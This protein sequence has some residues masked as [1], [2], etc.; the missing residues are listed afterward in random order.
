MIT[1]VGKFKAAIWSPY[2]SACTIAVGQD[3]IRFTH[4]DLADLRHVVDRLM[5]EALLLDLPRDEVLPP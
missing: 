3:E 5:Q 4:R 2:P 1:T